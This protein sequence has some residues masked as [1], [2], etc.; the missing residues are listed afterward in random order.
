MLPNIQA[1]KILFVEE[2]THD[3]PDNMERM[4]DE[5]TVEII[6]DMLHEW[7]QFFNSDGSKN[8]EG[9]IRHISKVLS[10]ITKDK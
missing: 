2:D 10:E 5:E 4:L 8:N 9:V 3:L 7:I 6:C 1:A